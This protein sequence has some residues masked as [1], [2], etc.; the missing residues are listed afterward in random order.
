MTTYLQIPEGGGGVSTVASLA[1]LPAVGGTGDIYLLLDTGR[2]MWWNA[3]TSAWEN[4]D[5][6]IWS[7]SIAATTSI[8]PTVTSGVLTADLK[9][10]NTAASSANLKA[11]TTIKGGVGAAQGLHVEIPE[12]TGSQTG[13][14]TSADWATFNGKQAGDATLTAL[15]GLDGTSGVVV[16]TAADTFTKRTI[17]GTANRVS[18]SNGD[19]V[20]GNPTINIDTTLFPSPIA[21]DVGLPLVTSAANTSSWSLPQSTIDLNQSGFVSWGGAGNY[22]SYVPS[23]GVFTVLRSGV[24]RIGS[25]KKI[26]TA[27]VVNAVTLTRGKSYMIAIS[28]N[29][30]LVAI[31][32]RTLYSADMATYM[33]NFHAA[34]KGYIFLFSIF[35]DTVGT[36]YH[37][38]KQNHPY[39]YA[40]E[41]AA[42]DHFR[43]GHVFIGNGGLISVLSAANRTIQTSGNAAL[44]DHGNVTTLADATGV[45]MT[46]DCMYQNAGGTMT[47]LNRCAF[48]ITSGVPVVGNTYTNNGSSFTVLHFTAGV[49][50]CWQSA[51]TTDPSASGTLAGT[52]TLTYSSWSE[53]RVVPSIYLSANV[54]T[55]LATASN[56]NRWGIFAI[57]ATGDDLQTPST[58]A[59][60]PT[61]IGV[62]S[63]TAYSGAN[64]NAA[65]ASLGTGSVPDTS[66]FLLPPEMEALEPCLMGFVVIDGNSRSIPAITSNGFVNGVRSY[67]NTGSGTGGAGASAVANAV[68]VSTSTTNFKG[69]LSSADVNVQLALDS[70]AAKSSA[71]RAVTSDPTITTTDRTILCDATS[72]PI[73]V[74]LPAAASNLGRMMW[75]K[76]TD[77]SA[78]AVVIDG[79][80]SETIDGL[81]TQSIA[82][83]GKCVQIQCDGSNWYIL[84]T[85]WG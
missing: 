4:I 40:S 13:V 61:F 79:N 10:S 68:N 69:W 16:E 32:W 19:G 66:Q 7:G 56:T 1:D 31:D 63:T 50:H 67:R 3:L 12:A 34:F 70:I 2:L 58:A 65:I 33:A 80:S 48:V 77:A 9:L 14:I 45:A 71:I 55:P 72:A 83:Q 15:A 46:I 5:T 27:G 6:D 35:V 47:G 51:G 84:S 41:I 38:M 44:D 49:A 59:P 26:W 76:K 39:D 25:L 52:P 37:V 28:D 11:T 57:Y 73:T 64:A 8:T 78:N 81:T 53:I 22:Y 54:P 85:V 17:T 75:I 23:T 29:Q 20:S 74:N 36:S 62:P 21:G 82:S 30:T 43:L 42:H 24:G 18:V 60:I